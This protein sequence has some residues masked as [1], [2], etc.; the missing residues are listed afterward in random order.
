MRLNQEL[1]TRLYFFGLVFFVCTLPFQR[2]LPPTYGLSVLLAAVLIQFPWKYEWR[3]R[4]LRFYLA[5][6]FFVFL[7]VAGVF[8]S[9]DTGA[10]WREFGRLLPLF[11]G[12]L[13]IAIGPPLEKKQIHRVLFYYVLAVT[14]ST[15]LSLLIGVYNFYAHQELGDIVSP[16]NY[17]FYGKL[18][19]FLEYQ[20]SYYSLYVLTAL[21]IALPGRWS[22]TGWESAKFTML[23]RGVSLFLTVVLFL[24]SARTQLAAF[25]IL[26]PVYLIFTGAE[27]LTRPKLTILIFFTVGILFAALLLPK[28]TRNRVQELSEEAS[29]TWGSDEQDVVNTRWYLWGLSKDLWSQRP[30]L[31]WGTDAAESKLVE[32]ARTYLDA[33]SQKYSTRDVLGSNL[34]HKELFLNDF[35]LADPSEAV[36]LNGENTRLDKF[37]TKK[38]A[39]AQWQGRS[40]H[41]KCDSGAHVGVQYAGLQVGRVYR[42]QFKAYNRLNGGMAVFNGS[43][44]LTY[45]REEA[46]FGGIEKQGVFFAKDSVITF[47]TAEYI[48][49]DLFISDLQLFDFGVLSEGA[50]SKELPG[51]M[52]NALGLYKHRYNAHSQY[53][54]IAI[55]YGLVGLILFLVPLIWLLAVGFRTSNWVQVGISASV[56]ISLA[57]EH[58]L[59]REAGLFFISVL[60]PFAFYYLSE[61]KP[62]TP[63][64]KH[65]GLDSK[66]K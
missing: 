7:I 22:K 18:S 30:L 44:R 29:Q 63:V 60:V 45:V 57:T 64:D 42:F 46:A 5:Q 17:L 23:R 58:M 1:K 51:R 39:L 10:A 25:F 48:P 36:R 54:Q 49:S 19:Y 33:A 14:L 32:Q 52:K 34:W 4:N 43:E 20:A 41:L 9:P 13:F 61:S 12:P 16:L 59:Q 50:A 56:L 11:F 37:Q 31:G 8:W 24:L 55:D 3:E 47:Q 2:I 53:A 15:F 65:D 6:L 35:Y 28:V 38:G 21:I 66:S 26:V 62:T 40:L 27:K